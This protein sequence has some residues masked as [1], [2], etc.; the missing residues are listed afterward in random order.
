MSRPD[1][2][3]DPT[4]ARF[5]RL[6]SSGQLKINYQ[7]IVDIQDLNVREITIS[8]ATGVKEGVEEMCS[9]FLRFVAGI[10]KEQKLPQGP[11]YSLAPLR[12]GWFNEH[13][14]GALDEAL[15]IPKSMGVEPELIKLEINEKDL[16]SLPARS[17]R[18]LKK[19]RRS[20]LKLCLVCRD[21]MLTSLRL[22]SA[23]PLDSIKISCRPLRGGVSGLREREILNTIISACH[24]LNLKVIVFGVKEEQHLEVLK[25]MG[26]RL[27]SGEY[28]LNPVSLKRLKENLKEE[29]KKVYLCP[30]A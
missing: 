8:L 6:S 26:C 4:D 19:L 21:T 15:E 27:A 1:K 14:S 16:L 13:G 25:N 10:I 22:L 9:G 3:P 12:G 23:V 2:S 30:G 11:V 18:L 29:N 7:P 17:H 20:R 5:S 28:F 24:K